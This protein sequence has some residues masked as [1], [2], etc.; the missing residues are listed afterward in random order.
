[1][2]PSCGRVFDANNR[3][4]FNYIPV[5]SIK[6]RVSVFRRVIIQGE[7]SAPETESCE[8]DDEALSELL[9]KTY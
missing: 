4:Q 3:N 9:H 1:M 2:F 6:L 5:K 8:M 7:S